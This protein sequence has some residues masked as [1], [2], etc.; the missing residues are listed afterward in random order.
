MMKKFF[1]SDRK[2]LGSISLLFF[3]TATITA[4]L[5]IL[6]FDA[7]EARYALKI[8]N[9]FNAITTKSEETERVLNELESDVHVYA[10]FTPGEEDQ[11]LISILERYAA[12]S[13]HFSFSVENLIQNPALVHQISSSLD[14]NSVTNDCLIVHGKKYD[15]TRVLTLFD[16]IVQAYDPDS[17]TFYIDGLNYEQRLSESIVYVTAPEVPSIQLLT[18]HGELSLEEISAMEELLLG[19]NYALTSIDLL[20]GDELDSG[21]PL[22]ILSPAKDLTTDQL[23]K[24]DTFVK[25]GGSIFISVDFTLY[26]DL[27]NF[28]SLYRSFGFIRKKGLVVAQEDDDESYYYSSPAVLIPYMEMAEPT[29]LLIEH[30][31]TMLILAGSSA[32]EEPQRT[33]SLLTNY[34]LLRSGKAY[35]R[36]TSDESNDITQR[37]TDQRGT[38]PL[39]LT[40]ERAFDDGTRSKAFIIG[41]S[42]VF[43]D[44]WLYQNTYSAEF[45]LSMIGYLSP[46]SPIKLSI[47]A[48]DAIRPPLHVVNPLYNW[49]AIVILPFSVIAAA[50]IVL[51]PRRRR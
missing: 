23:Q 10:L 12:S 18:G 37:E 39:A 5:L 2:K 33:D 40:A 9:S 22:M 21:S 44:S 4:G 3:I 13:D 1:L 51:L 45:L 27:P 30:K 46:S 28:E 26:D 49:I 29:A 24:I 42:S 25:D 35:L 47:Q 43:T 19:Y 16:Y 32:F 36:D 48:K 7:L 38:F 11:T 20:G 34:V 6:A 14:D 31:Q 15:R 17:G 8:D 50:L 41:N